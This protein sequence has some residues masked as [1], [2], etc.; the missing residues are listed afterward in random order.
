MVAAGRTGAGT[1]RHESDPAPTITGK[2]TAYLLSDL[3]DY[4]PRPLPLWTQERPSYTITGGGTG[5]GGAEPFGNGARQQMK[6]AGGAVRVTVQEAAILQSFP[7]DYPWQGSKTAQYR[8]VGDAVPPL[9]AAH[10]LQS[11]GAGTLAVTNGEAQPA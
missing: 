11:V 6:K 8:Q 5:S 4:Q 10:I 2:G 9:M 1:P 3:G 7:A